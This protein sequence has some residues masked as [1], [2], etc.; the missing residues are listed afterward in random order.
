MVNAEGLATIEIHPVL[1]AKRSG[2]PAEE[3]GCAES[4]ADLPY[5]VRLGRCSALLRCSHSVGSG[6]FP[7]RAWEPSK[8]NLTPFCRPL[9][10]FLFVFLIISKAILQHHASL[11]RIEGLR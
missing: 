2:S 5:R 1:C 9:F 4:W 7:R 8:I 6:W 10:A 3:Q 11:Q